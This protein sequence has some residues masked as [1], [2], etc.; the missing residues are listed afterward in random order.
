MKI[1]KSIALLLL[2]FLPG[3]I[4]LFLQGFGKNKFD[5]P[6]YYSTGVDTL[7]ACGQ[8]MVAGQYH[9]DPIPAISGQLM[10]K[11][12]LY[13]FGVLSDSNFVSQRNNLLTFLTKF[14]SE[15]R[16]QVASLYTTDSLYTTL[17]GYSILKYVRVDSS[18]F[19]TFVSCQLF[20]FDG[21][22][23]SSEALPMVLVDKERKIR[24]YFNPND[25]EEID[26]LNIEVNIL[27][28]E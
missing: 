15:E 2:L 18:I 27:L 23:A 3:A 28:N 14:K 20:V 7:T 24:G 22:K 4:Y 8:L 9:V 1:F 16:L 6:I 11:V 12:T 13:D 25:L 21:D 10:D 17:E 26:R 19:K 5:I